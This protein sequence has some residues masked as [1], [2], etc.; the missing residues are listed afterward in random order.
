MSK[1]PVN[2]WLRHRTWFLRLSIPPSLRQHFGGKDKLVESLGTSDLHVAIAERDRRVADY[3]AQF[4]RLRSSTAAATQVHDAVT[5]ARREKTETRG[6]QAF[7]YM[8]LYWEVYSIQR[9]VGDTLEEVRKLLGIPPEDFKPGS[10]AWLEHG[11]TAAWQKI[12]TPLAR[13]DGKIYPEDV[14]AYLVS[15]AATPATAG[16]TSTP[17]DAATPAPA[18]T[19]ATPTRQ[20][21]AGERFSEAV[22]AHLKSIKSE[23][24]TTHAEYKRM[25]KAFEDYCRNAPITQITRDVAADFLDKHLLEKREISKRTRNLYASLLQSIFKTAIRRGRFNAANPFEGQKLDVDEV[26]YEPFTDDEIT[27]LFAGVKYEVRPK[28]HTKQTALPWAMLIGAYSGA[29]RE[30]ICQL[31]KEDFQE[32]DGVPFFDI[33]NGN[34]NNL[35]NKSAPRCVPVHSQLIKCGLLDYV[36][37]LPDGSRL[38]PALKPRKSRNGKLGADLGDDFHDYRCS[39]DVVDRGGGL[40]FHSFRHTITNMLERLGVPQTDAARVT[41]HKIDGITYSVYSHDGPGLKRLQKIVE[42][43]KHPGLVIKRA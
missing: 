39:V 10:K 19:L 16:A 7:S 17:P 20:S 9:L 36:K 37:A 40:N 34:G 33:H 38:F 26:H 35:K 21:E 29:R 4:E 11:R 32:R 41:G 25:A 18:V 22:A 14:I 2:L 27:K 6:Q 1:T 8:W 31:R 13:A 15:T 24:P 28:Q 42:K 43:I 5:V 3:H 12:F 23:N 30:E